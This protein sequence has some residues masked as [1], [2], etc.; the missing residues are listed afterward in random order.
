M[1][2]RLINTVI[3]Q[4]GAP[5]I[6]ESVL[7]DFPAAGNTGRLLVSTDTQ[8]LYR[9]NGTSFDLIGGPGSGTITGSGTAGKIAKFTGSAVIANSIMTESAATITVAGN[10]T[11]SGGAYILTSSGVFVTNLSGN[12]YVQT[13]SAV[14]AESGMI[15]NE[16]GVPI[17]ELFNKNGTMF[18]Y[19][20]VAGSS[21]FNWNNSGQFFAS[22]FVRSG[23][24]SSQFLK[25][26]GSI[27][28]NTYLTASGAVTSIT[29]TANQITASAATGAVTLSLPQSIA[30]SSNVT[31]ATIKGTSFVKSG[32]TSSQFLKADGSIDSNT[33][34]TASGA[35]TS[36]T[37]TANQITA[38]AATG[39]VTLSLPATVILTTA[40]KIQTPQSTTP[41]TPIFQVNGSVGNFFVRDS[42]QEAYF[43]GASV[44]YFGIVNASGVLNM[45][46]GNGTVAFTL[47][48]DQTFS[49][50]GST[51]AKQGDFITLNA[52]GYWRFQNPGNSSSYLGY[53]TGVLS[54]A[55]T[56]DFILRSDVA[57]K[58]A[59]GG[60][61][62]ALTITSAQ[63]ATFIS[64][65]NVNGAADNAN[66]ALNVSGCTY[67]NSFSPTASTKSSSFTAGDNTTY[68]FT[69]GAGQTAT[70]ENP[71]FTN[72]IIIIKNYTS[73]SLTVAGYA[74]GTNIVD[75]TNTA[76][77]SFALTGGKTVIMQQDG[78]SKTFILSIY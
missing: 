59:T 58:F 27:D 36:I 26:D 2:V 47:N 57:L 35:V 71:A 68:I 17:W 16:N 76:V 1:G 51:T 24:T 44:A 31:F 73:N 62:L 23:G 48:S 41:Y 25:A 60:S 50:T 64:R 40:L 39:A 11:L 30:T 46:S 18:L 8:A 15:Y 43:F 52:N 33:Y 53:G 7:T 32:G 42:G 63:I 55:S 67:T 38:S 3:N 65:V 29:G 77:S 9:D 14:G 22:Q 74:G 78:G 21:L 28:S 12:A 4:L 20:Y 56:T 34:L 10:V 37:G 70:L 5:S 13:N 54:G 45:V 75:T 19:S 69:G 66:F 49:Y 6:Y 61:N 72:K